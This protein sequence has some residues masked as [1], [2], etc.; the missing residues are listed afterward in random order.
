MTLQIGEVEVQIIKVIN[1]RM[2]TRN[3]D[4]RI[5]CRSIYGSNIY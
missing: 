5:V 2:T 3:V 1:M 4:E